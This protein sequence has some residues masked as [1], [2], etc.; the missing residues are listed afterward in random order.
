MRIIGI[1]QANLH[2]L[3][4]V[5]KDEVSQIIRAPMSIGF[6]QYITAA[7]NPDRFK[8]RATSAGFEFIPTD[9]YVKNSDDDEANRRILQTDPESI[10]A[11]VIVTADVL[12]YM[13]SLERKKAQKIQIFI[14]AITA[15]ESD[16]SF[17][18]SVHSQATIREKQYTLID[19]GKYKEGL[20]LTK[21]KDM[22]ISSA[23]SIKEKGGDSSTEKLNVL[24][25][26]GHLDLYQWAEARQAYLYAQISAYAHQQDLKNVQHASEEIS[27]LSG[28]AKI[29]NI[30][31]KGDQKKEVRNLTHM[32]K[33]ILR[34]PWTRITV[35]TK[36][37]R[38]ER[39]LFALRKYQPASMSTLLKEIG[40]IEHQTLLRD[41]HKLETEGLVKSVGKTKWT[42][43]TLNTNSEEESETE[44]LLD[45]TE[46]AKRLRVSEDWLYRHWRELPSSRKLSKK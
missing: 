10:A 42:R 17:P 13:E 23:T 4:K 26:A 20:L 32:E 30:R 21:W 36:A 45:I 2:T 9:P 29:I 16:G 7:E 43:Y 37:Q 46:A 40:N 15:A 38:H 35:L 1:G 11:L 19:L 22:S 28:L 5:I 18:L 33:K 41:L 3:L 14:A 44:K 31:E 24:N 39:I 8:K 6:S 34:R 12:D 27:F 25:D